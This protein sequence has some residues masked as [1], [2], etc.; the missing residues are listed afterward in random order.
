[1]ITAHMAREIADRQLENYGPGQ[2]VIAGQMEYPFGWVFGWLRNPATGL[3][4]HDIYGNSPFI[5]DRRDGSVHSC[6]SGEELEDV[7]ERY[8]RTGSTEK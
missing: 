5:V 1:M 3:D 6:G 2:Y 8:S 4:P 7:I